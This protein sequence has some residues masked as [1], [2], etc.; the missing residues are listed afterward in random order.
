M[1]NDKC[2]KYPGAD[3]RTS[4]VQFRAAL[5]DIGYLVAKDIA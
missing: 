4:G 3:K 2:N 1:Q 5:E